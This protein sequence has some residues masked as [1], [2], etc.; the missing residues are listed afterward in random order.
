M[1]WPALGTVTP[2][3]AMP[4]LRVKYA[5]KTQA[6]SCWTRLDS[7]LLTKLAW[8]A[9]QKSWHPGTWRHF[10]ASRAAQSDARAIR[11]LE[12]RERER[13]RISEEGS[14]EIQRDSVAIQFISHRHG[15]LRSTSDRIAQSASS[16]SER[17]RSSRSTPGISRSPCCSTTSARRNVGTVRARPSGSCSNR[18]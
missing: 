3:Q 17:S 2:H 7:A 5:S 6:A 8:K 13:G 16:S 10:V 4:D 14:C 11:L 15:T 12:R 9:I 18:D 1:H